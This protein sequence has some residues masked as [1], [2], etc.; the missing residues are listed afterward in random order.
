M[1]L[2]PLPLQRQLAP[3]RILCTG[4]LSPAGAQRVCTDPGGARQGARCP[5]SWGK[6]FRAGS[7]ASGAARRY[8][9]RLEGTSPAGRSQRLSRC[10]Q[11]GHRQRLGDGYKKGGGGEA[12]GAA[13]RELPAPA[14]P[15]P[16]CPA[17]PGAAAPRSCGQS[18][19]S[20]LSGQVSV[21][22][23]VWKGRGRSSSSR[24]VCAAPAPSVR[25]AALLAA[26]GLCREGTGLLP[27][28][29]RR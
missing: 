13:E 28:P 27:S 21:C 14:C 16:A 5:R 10:K 12:A 29:L 18:P 26:S 11:C 3:S 20:A 19:R 24:R 1:F 2:S 4:L 9:S 17:C 25:A 15:C 23:E 7:G 8:T 22:G 6:P